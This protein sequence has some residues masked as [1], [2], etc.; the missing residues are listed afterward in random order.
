MIDTT[1]TNENS[2]ATDAGPLYDYIHLGH[3]VLGN[4]HIYRTGDETVFVFDDGTLVDRVGLEARPLWHYERFV[5]DDGPGW[6]DYHPS[7]EGDFGD[8]FDF[9]RGDG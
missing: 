5:E 6:A 9:L 8:P 3:D 2:S 7:V 4:E 1:R